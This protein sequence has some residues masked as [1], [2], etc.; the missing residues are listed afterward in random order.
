MRQPPLSRA[1]GSP[2]LPLPPW[3]NAASWRDCFYS[4]A[5]PEVAEPPLPPLPQ[6]L[7]HNG[8]VRGRLHAAVCR[9]ARPGLLR[10]ELPGWPVPVVSFCARQRPVP[11]PPPPTHTDLPTAFYPYKAQLQPLCRYAYAPAIAWF[12]STSPTALP[13][14]TLIAAKACLAAPPAPP[15]AKGCQL[16]AYFPSACSKVR[17]R[18]GQRPAPGVS[19]PACLCRACKRLRRFSSLEAPAHPRATPPCPPQVCADDALV[20]PDTQKCPGGETPSCPKL[21]PY[22][23]QNSDFCTASEAAATNPC[24]PNTYLFPLSTPPACIPKCPVSGASTFATTT[25]AGQDLYYC[26]DAQFPA[27][28]V[29][30][31]ANCYNTSTGLRSAPSAALELASAASTSA[32]SCRWAARCLPPAAAEARMLLPPYNHGA[33]PCR[34]RPVCSGSASAAAAPGAFSPHPRP[35]LMAGTPRLGSQLA[36]GHSYPHLLLHTVQGERQR[37][38][39]GRRLHQHHRPLPLWRRPV[40]L[41]LPSGARRLHAAALHQVPHLL[42]LGQGGRRVRHQQVPSRQRHAHR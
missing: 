5:A 22:S 7:A 13:V 6:V 26:A 24:P 17:P 16:S 32:G 25:A 27:T 15:A 8:G 20:D 10:A 9:S 4:Q 23:I 18:R 1:A 37:R 30:L 39:C 28:S 41:W 31:L 29:L 42:E 3:G 19:A 33:A 34:L 38:L 35:D 36:T 21:C 2:H 14:P 12:C 40:P 11:S